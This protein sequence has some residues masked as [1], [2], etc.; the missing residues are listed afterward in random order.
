MEKHPQGSRQVSQNPLL[1]KQTS[2]G[3][4]WLLRGRKGAMEA[5]GRFE[6]GLGIG[7]GHGANILVLMGFLWRCGKRLILLKTQTSI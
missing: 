5:T 6:C 3:S 2:S 4:D 1:L 7:T